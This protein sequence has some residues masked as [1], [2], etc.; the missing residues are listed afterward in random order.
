MDIRTGM[1]PIIMKLA[2]PVSP[3]PFLHRWWK[4]IKTRFMTSLLKQFLV[5]QAISLFALAVALTSPCDV[6]AVSIGEVVLQSRL[7]EPLL[8]QVDLTVGSGEHIENSCLSLIAPDPLD[9]DISGYLTKAT[10]SLNSDG[11]RQ[12]ISI[13]SRK[14]FIDAFAKLRLQV[15]CPGTGSVIKTL[16]ILPDL[17]ELVPQAPITA[18]TGTSEAEKPIAPSLSDKHDIVSGEKQHNIRDALP[19]VKKHIPRESSRLAHKRPPRVEHS[20]SNAQ[21]GSIVFRLKLSG[22]PLDE[23]RIGKISAE[24]RSLLLARQKLL[25]ADDQMASFLAMQNQVKQLQDELGEIKLQLTKLGVNPVALA[26]SAVAPSVTAPS[27]TPLATGVPQENR[28]KPA[29][30]IKQPAVQQSAPDL[31]NGIIAAL[32]LVL[33]I[34]A[35]WQGLRHYTKTKALSENEAQP[36]LKPF[37][38]PADYVAN[39]KVTPPVSEKPS[40]QA[41]PAKVNSAPA[42]AAAPTPSTSR[43]E[44]A[45]APAPLPPRRIEAVSEIDSMLE[46]AELYSTHGRPAKAAEILQEIIRQNPSKVEAWTL[47]LSIFSSLAKAAEFEKTAREFLNHHEG[48]PSWSGIHALGR[49]FDQNNPLYADSNTVF[50][51]SPI[52]PEAASARRPVGDIL[53]DMGILSKQDLQ[54]CLDTFDPKKHGRFG[55]YLVARKVITLA[56][57]DQALLQQQGV[58]NEVKPGTMP[59][60]QDME[61]FLADFDPKRDGSVSEFLASRNAVT[62]DQLSQLLKQ[63]SGSGAATETPQ[64]NESDAP[65]GNFVLVPPSKPPTTDLEFESAADKNKPLPKVE[66]AGPSSPEIML[67][68]PEINLDLKSFSPSGKKPDSQ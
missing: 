57:L 2:T 53:M 42:V 26:S 66:P 43:G 14:T 1:P 60:L 51:N 28:P 4:G 8:A 16:T 46:E 23:S 30:A 44:V 63:T 45:I 18:P 36:D 12:F 56:Q 3:S 5:P 68:F 33:V 48:S 55:G 25:D 32:G 15:K 49:T 39:T 11:K 19:V 38:K 34:L 10:L 61:N 6:N 64:A 24:E 47:L 58:G 62:P 17:D 20:A 41:Q 65:T 27:A 22:E 13:S 21:A 31:E 40:S 9:E 50:S 29:N 59:S 54:N 7:G 37:L 35:L 52:L 67:D